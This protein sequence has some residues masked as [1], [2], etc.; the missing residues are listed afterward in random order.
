[1]N[2]SLFFTGLGFFTFEFLCILVGV[3]VMSG[4]TIELVVKISAVLMAVGLNALFGVIMIKGL[5]E[6]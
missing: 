2:K 1:M 3:L 5:F 6:K 4:A